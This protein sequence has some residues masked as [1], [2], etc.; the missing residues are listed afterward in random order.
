MSITKNPAA[1]SC[2]MQENVVLI[3]FRF[4]LL[5]ALKTSCHSF[6]GFFYSNHGI[7]SPHGIDPY[8]FC[9]PG[10]DQPPGTFPIPGK[11]WAPVH[12]L[13]PPP[14]D[15]VLLPA[16]PPLSVLLRQFP[17]AV[18]PA[19]LLDWAFATNAW[20]TPTPHQLQ[21]AWRTHTHTPA[22]G[23]PQEPQGIGNPAA[24][25]APRVLDLHPPE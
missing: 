19:G 14:P 1:G 2:A 6:Y 25:P 4:F 11:T 20:R 15:R 24:P 16:F 17:P 21:A 23:R 22:C 7:C 9:V 13:T 12:I 10:M 3:K 8:P 18:P 5:S